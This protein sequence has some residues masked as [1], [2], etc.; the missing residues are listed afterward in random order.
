MKNDL[1]Y[2]RHI[3]DAIEKIESYTDMSKDDFMSTSHWQDATIRNLEIIGEAVKRLSEE[4]KEH[5]PEI[6]WR[7]VAGLRDI[8]IHHYMGVDL[9]TVWNVVKNDLPGLKKIVARVLEQY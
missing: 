2:L 7:N 5:N 1:V 9:E 8:L 4:L 3:N 6:P